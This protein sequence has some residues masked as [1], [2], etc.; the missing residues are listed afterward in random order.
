MAIQFYPI[1]GYNSFSKIYDVGVKFRSGSASCVVIFSD[2][3][4]TEMPESVNKFLGISNCENNGESKNQTYCNV[5]S[6][7]C[8]HIIY[9]GVT[10][11]KRIAKKAVVRNRIKRLMRESLRI[12]GKE[13]EM[14]NF[15]PIKKIIISYHFAP[16]HPMQISLNDVLPAVKNLLERAFSYYN[17][18]KNETNNS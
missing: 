2:E 11:S 16:K 1:K 15:F 7:N 5:H 3:I 8:K 14:K 12:A 9:Y 4:F 6:N 13:M 17:N 18:R 10:V